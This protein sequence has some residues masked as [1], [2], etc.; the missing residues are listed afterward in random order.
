MDAPALRAPGGPVVET[1]RGVLKP[2]TWYAVAE[3]SAAH[4]SGS[5][6]LGLCRRVRNPRRGS[7]AGRVARPSGR[8]SDAAV[9]GCRG[10]SL[11]GHESA[12]GA[13]ARFR[14]CSWLGGR[15]P[16]GRRNANGSDGTHSRPGPSGPSPRS[17]AKPHERRYG[18]PRG[19]VRPPPQPSHLWR[20]SSTKDEDSLVRVC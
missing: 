14:P 1:A 10:L 13:R 16:Q 7:I 17:A 11:K 9:R 19:G 18:S 2:R 3:G 15:T 8:W 12:R 4:A 6:G 20:A 5:A